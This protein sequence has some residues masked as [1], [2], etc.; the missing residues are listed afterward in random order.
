MFGISCQCWQE[1]NSWYS[2][3]SLSSLLATG[4]RS[5]IAQTSSAADTNALIGALSLGKGLRPSLGSPKSQSPLP[6][7]SGQG[8]GGKAFTSELFFLSVSSLSFSCCSCSLAQH[9]LL[10]P[11]C[12]KPCESSP[13]A[14]P[15]ISRVL[16][17]LLTS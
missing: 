4:Q 13:F 14:Y 17:S 11:S 1:L 9:F 16:E 8:R 6:Q 2:C 5:S 12:E 15:N 10:V 7:A 3:W